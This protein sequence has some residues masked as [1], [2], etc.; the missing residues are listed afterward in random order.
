MLDTYINRHAG[1][2][3]KRK[4]KCRTLFLRKLST[5]LIKTITHT[6]VYKLPWYTTISTCDEYVGLHYA[7]RSLLLYFASLLLRWLLVLGALC[8][9]FRFAPIFFRHGPLEFLSL[10]RHHE[11]C[12][13]AKQAHLQKQKHVI[14]QKLKYLVGPQR[15][16]LFIS[17]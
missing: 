2:P 13:L 15:N 1:T 8:L 11:R 5:R 9:W 4:T 7:D 3:D 14:D 16:I 17:S 10:Y 6:T 12:R